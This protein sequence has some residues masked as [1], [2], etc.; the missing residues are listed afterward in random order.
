MNYNIAACL[1]AT[2]G[3]CISDNKMLIAINFTLAMANL[4]SAIWTKIEK[5]AC[6]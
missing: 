5:E 3:A 2:F 6:S 4:I 1:I